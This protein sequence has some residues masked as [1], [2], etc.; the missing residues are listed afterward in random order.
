MSVVK[1][2]YNPKTFQYERARVTLRDIA[3]YICGLLFTGLLFSGGMIA[4]HDSLT[5]SETEKALLVE[6]ELLK[7]HKPVLVRQ[8]AEVEDK[9]VALEKNDRHL[10]ARLF[11]AAPPESAP[12]V[13]TLSREQVLLADASSFRQLLDVVKTRSE[14]LKEKSLAGNNSFGDRIRVTKDHLDMLASIPSIQ[15]ISNDQ[16]DLLVSGFGE[17]IN[18]F[19]KGNYHHPGI[20]FAAA[21]GTSV[22][23]T[24]MG[25]VSAVSRTNLQAGYGNYVEITHGNG[26]VTRYAHLGEIS[27]RKGQ[28]VVKGQ[29]I[30]T[31]GSSGGSVAPHLH[32]EV[33][34]DGEAV[35]PVHYLIEGLRSEQYAELLQLGIKKNQSLD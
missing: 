20:D 29:V 15:P 22:F 25:R 24:A 14:S 18:P 12:P 28:T 9:L 30:G 23:S 4:I 33:I 27:V 1:Y 19:H 34:R 31:V 3:W 21:R 17:R 10:Y 7:K 11:N 8:L 6:N 16:L 13:N 2:Q 5:E 26:F 35:D 32:Y